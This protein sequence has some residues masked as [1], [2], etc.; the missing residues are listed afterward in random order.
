MSVPINKATPRVILL[1]IQDESARRLPLEVE[2]LPQHLPVVFLLTEK[3]EQISIASGSLLEQLYGDKTLDPRSSFY[4]HQSKMAQVFSSASNMMMV[5]PIKLPSAKRASLRLSVELVPTSLKQ[6]DGSYKTVTRVIWHADEVPVD[7]FALGKINPTYREGNVTA[8]LS[9]ESLGALVDQS[10]TSYFVPS[11]LIPVVDL[12]TDYR[13]SAGNNYGIQL[14]T[15][16]DTDTY[17][18]NDIVS[19]TA[20]SFIYRLMFMQKGSS[21]TPTVILNRYSEQST[22]F[23]FKRGIT[24]TQTG[25]KYSFEEVAVKNY[26]QVYDI[27][28]APQMAPFKNVHVYEENIQNVLMNLANDYVV[29]GVEAGGASKQFTIPGV[30]GQVTDPDSIHLINFVT[31]MDIHGNPYPTMDFTAS[32]KFDGVRFGR[33]VT[34]YAKGGDDGFPTTL[35]VTDKIELARQFDEA[36]RDWCNNTFIEVN[37][38]FDSARYPFSTLWDSG[39]SL[40][41]KLAMLKP[42][43]RHKRINVFLGTHR[44]YDYNAAKDKFVKVRKLSGAEEVTMTSQLSTAASLYP[45]SEVFGTQ[46]CRCMIVTRSGIPVSGAYQERLPFTFSLA[47]LVAPYMGAAEGVWKN[48]Y[49]FDES[50]RNIDTFFDPETVNVTYQS[51]QVYNE[52]WKAGAIWVQYFDRQSLFFPA[53]QTVYPDDTSVLNNLFTVMAC[54]YLER[55]CEEVWRELVGNGKFNAQKFIEESDKKI[56]Q[57]TKGRFDDRFIIVPRTRLTENDILRGYSWETIIEIYSNNMKT[58]NVTRVVARRM[59][60]YTGDAQQ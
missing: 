22:D 13:G 25:M 20:K 7:E 28:A 2:N 36:V 58:V 34:V 29:Q 31:G 42:M 32:V 56:V 43:G 5:Q 6:K 9:S 52:S 18:T 15:P 49:S 59:S 48:E 53:F 46:A 27:Q 1:G 14:L 38:I 23:T 4:T 47:S 3:S 45:E 39:F 60:D 40:E 17:P 33:N 57:K 30:Y 55:V 11:A 24:D 16:F 44:I 12:E 41:T 26:E 37:P 19:E 35:G 51:P 54:S 50:P 10:G 21:N 8:G